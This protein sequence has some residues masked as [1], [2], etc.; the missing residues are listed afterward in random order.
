[1]LNLS[2]KTRRYI[3]KPIVS[4]LLIFSIIFASAPT[5]AFVKVPIGQTNFSAAPVY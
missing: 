1:M 3:F 2:K 5:G 4:F